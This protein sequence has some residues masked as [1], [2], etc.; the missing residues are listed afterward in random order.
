MGTVCAGVATELGG[1]KRG[2]GNGEGKC[3]CVA[4]V[5]VGCVACVCVLRC[6][7]GVVVKACGVCVV[8]WCGGG[9]VSGGE[10]QGQWNTRDVGRCWQALPCQFKQKMNRQR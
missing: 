8:G 9:G 3:V 4:V 5:G 10:E 7:G 2:N 6:V 1:N